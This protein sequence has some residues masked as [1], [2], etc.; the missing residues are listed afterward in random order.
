MLNYVK[1]IEIALGAS[2][3][4]FP[5]FLLRGKDTGAETYEKLKIVNFPC[6]LFVF[7][8]SF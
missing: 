7:M 5:L 6:N 8:V 1:C 4:I 3:E 2:E